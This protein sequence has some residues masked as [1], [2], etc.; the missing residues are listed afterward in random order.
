MP[1]QQFGRSCVHRQQQ[2]VEKTQPIETFI[3]Y[4]IITVNETK[5]HECFTVGI[6][7]TFPDTCNNILRCFDLP[8]A[9]ALNSLV[10]LQEMFLPTELHTGLILKIDV[11]SNSFDPIRPINR[12]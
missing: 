4:R 12:D 3:S 9:V 6:Y 2:E 10:E 7:A 11:F 5:Q 8:N 1:L